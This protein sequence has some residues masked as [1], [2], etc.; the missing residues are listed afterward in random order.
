MRELAFL[1]QGLTISLTDLRE[2]MQ[3]EEGNDSGHLN[4]T[5]YSTEGLKDFVSYLDSNREPLIL[6]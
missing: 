6:K 1:N 4:E 5:F 3:D 2:R